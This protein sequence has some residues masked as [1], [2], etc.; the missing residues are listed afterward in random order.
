MMMLLMIM[1]MMMIIM[2]KLTLNIEAFPSWG[3]VGSKRIISGHLL[4]SVNERPG[5]N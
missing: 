3:K 1:M 4:F 5:E 2:T